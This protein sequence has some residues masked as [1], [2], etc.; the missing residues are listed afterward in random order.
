MGKLL[1]AFCNALSTNLPKLLRPIDAGPLAESLGTLN[2]CLTAGAHVCPSVDAVA[3]NILSAVACTKQHRDAQVRHQT[4][5]LL[6]RIALL[7]Q[8]GQQET[9]EWLDSR[10]MHAAS[11]LVLPFS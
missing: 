11:S 1:P 7:T 4:A 10:E 2:A 8:R 5:L 6:T 9:L 3:R